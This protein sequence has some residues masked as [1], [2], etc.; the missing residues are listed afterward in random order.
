MTYT[1]SSITFEVKPDIMGVF[2]Y[3]GPPSPKMR[4][5][6]EGCWGLNCSEVK[7]VNMM[8]IPSIIAS[9]TPPMRFFN[10]FLS[11]CVRVCV[12]VCL[13]VRAMWGQPTTSSITRMHAKHR[14]YSKTRTTLLNSY[15]QWQSPTWQGR[16]FWRKEWR[17]W[18]RRMWWN[19][20]DLPFSW[21]EG[22]F[23]IKAE[24]F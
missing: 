14:S 19:S 18:Q 23:H 8:V 15:Q 7:R 24:I 17:P 3:D 22:E 12:R 21:D 13:C 2:L 4:R 10:E 6:G 1:S 5:G 16:H 20:T 9:K 11:E